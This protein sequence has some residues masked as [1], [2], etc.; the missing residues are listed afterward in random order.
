VTDA[1]DTDAGAYYS[2]SAEVLT[3]LGTGGLP[4]GGTL[5]VGASTTVTFRT[6]V[7]DSVPNNASVTNAARADYAAATGG[8]KYGSESNIVP[9]AITA[10]D[11]TITKTANDFAQGGRATWTMKVRNVGGTKL[12]SSVLVSDDIP[13]GVTNAVA[14]GSGWDCQTA[15]QKVLCQHAGPVAVGQTLP[16]ITMTG[17]VGNGARVVNVARVTSAQDQNAEN[18][19]AL[20]ENV[21]NVPKINV[22][23]GTTIQV[24]D[25]RPIAGDRI[26]ATATYIHYDGV[27]ST[28]TATLSFPTSIT[29]RSATVVGDVTGA[30]TITGFTV[31]CNLAEMREGQSVKVV[32]SALVSSAGS[33]G[34]T[35]VSEIQPTDGNVDPAQGNNT[36]AV[37]V[38]VLPVEP[39]VAPPT[40]LALTKDVA[41]APPAY[42]HPVTWRMTVTNTGEA[43]ATNTYFQDQ[44][45]ATATYVSGSVV[46]GAACDNR[47]GVVRCNT[48]TLAPG[49]T[50]TALITAKYDVIGEIING[51]TAYADGGVRVRASATTSAFG[52]K[53]GVRITTPARWP[54]SST[55]PATV[56]IRGLGPLKATGTK[57]SVTLPSNVKVASAPG[58]RIT[59][60]AGGTTVLTRSTGTLKQGAS[61]SFGITLRTPA[62]A[63]RVRLPVVGTATNTSKAT[64]AAPA[65]TVAH[66]VP[67]TG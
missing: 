55:A 43:A 2:G 30:C 17:T 54:R 7:R 39:A 31:T 36:A 44:L 19:Y 35:I 60:G 40:T 38:G 1:A 24:N 65:R 50:A 49:Q 26:T 62:T 61:R 34:T 46:G 16:E 48:G 51:V 52:S 32:V 20:T 59:R 37:I 18:D 12:T 21:F 66:A 45:P 47:G 10:P 15:L 5:P 28:S 64:S 3:A 9:S 13:A 29:P 23:F 41:G 57:M 33:G 4:G 42:G 67:V 14:K 6:T 63:T 27:P 56:V 22:D 58:F 25:R 53:I 8:I 11:L